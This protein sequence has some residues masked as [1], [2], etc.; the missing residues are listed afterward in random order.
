MN[1]PTK[2]GPSTKY[3]FENVQSLLQF[4]LDGTSNDIIELSPSATDQLQVAPTRTSKFQPKN[5]RRQ[6]YATLELPPEVPSDSP[7]DS[8]EL[9]L[10]PPDLRSQNQPLNHEGLSDVDT[11]LKSLVAP[12]LTS[13]EF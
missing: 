5:Y 6:T 9:T 10:Q 2:Y 12:V 11:M 4:L 8:K 7:S 3:Q 1:F 13:L